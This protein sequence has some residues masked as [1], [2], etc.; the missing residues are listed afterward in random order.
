M[1]DGSISVDL[2]PQGTLAERIRAGGF[3]LGGVLTKTGLGTIA[4]DGQ[5][6]IDI[7][8]EQWLY[9]SPLKADFALIHADRADYSGNLAYQLT[10]TNFNPV[11][12]MAGETVIVEP[13]EISPVGVIPPDNVSTSGILVD[14]IILRGAA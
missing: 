10:A 6:V 7:D 5:K 4:A 9:A 1:I 12:A 2:V 11:M 3:G 8:G 14:Y 13:R